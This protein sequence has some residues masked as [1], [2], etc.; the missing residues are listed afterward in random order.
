MARAAWVPLALLLL[1]GAMAFATGTSWGTFAIMLPIAA[2]ILL[3]LDAEAMLPVAFAA[4]LS[5]SLFG[6]HTSPISDTTTV[7]SVAAG[8]KQ[9][10]HVFSQMPYA[11]TAALASAIGFFVYGLSES[12]GLMLMTSALVAFV[13]LWT[14]T[15]PVP[16][17]MEQAA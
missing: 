11:W 5:G 8:V 7:A 6:D 1:T 2:Q 4:V 12:Q 14:Q 3:A 13:T 10:N 16:E 17:E 9:M 15:A